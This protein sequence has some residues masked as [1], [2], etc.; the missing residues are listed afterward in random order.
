MAKR[1]SRDLGLKGTGAG[2]GDKDRSPGWRKQYDTIN[3]PSGG[4]GPKKFH[5]VYSQAKPTK[6]AEAPHIRVI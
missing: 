4:K 3:W 2:K 1:N 6:D 5:K